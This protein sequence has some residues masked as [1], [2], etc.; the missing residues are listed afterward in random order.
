MDKTVAAQLV[1]TA[2][3]LTGGIAAGFVRETPVRFGVTAAPGRFHGVETVRIVDAVHVPGEPLDAVLTLEVTGGYEA[4]ICGDD[5]VGLEVVLAGGGNVQ[6]DEASV[7]L[8]QL[9]LGRDA[10]ELERPACAQISESGD[11]RAQLRLAVSSWAGGEHAKTWI[12]RFSN[13]GDQ[14]VA[15]LTAHYDDRQG[16]RVHLD[17]SED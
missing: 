10:V 8:R 15:I 5:A 13:T 4:N 11:F 2:A 1:G 16:W 6:T 3:L 7:Y 12:Y 9:A 14:V 17:E